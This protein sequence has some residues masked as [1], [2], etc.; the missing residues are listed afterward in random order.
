MLDLRLFARRDFVVA[1]VA[2]F[3][4]GAGAIALF[5]YLSGFA[6]RRPWASR[7][8]V[9]RPA[10]AAWSATSVVTAL[11]ARRLPARLSGR[12]QLGIG[13]IGVAA[14]QLDDDPGRPR[15]PGW[16]GASCPGCSWR[17]VF[18][19]MVN[20]ALGREAVASVPEGRGA[21]G[22][23]ANNTARYVGSAVGVTVVAVVASS[24]GTPGTGVSGLVHGWNVAALV[25]ALVSV[26]GGVVALALRPSGAVPAHSAAPQVVEPAG[27]D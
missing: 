9:P 1:T 20:A 17:A 26:A 7:P 4:T 19:G 23:G 12:T 21:L 13:L 14:G 10:D 16:V 2:A 25:T 3:A 6:R 18:S 11:L 24:A 22:S 8:S 15:A 27:R 5:S